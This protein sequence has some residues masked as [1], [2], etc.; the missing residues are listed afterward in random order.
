MTEKRNS[1][2]LCLA[3]KRRNENLRRRIKT[4]F[5]RSHELGKANGVDVA[6]V[7]R[8]NNQYYTFRS[9]DQPAWPLTMTDIVSGT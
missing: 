3:V 7:L 4:L 1:Q 2:V 8:K 9:I 5:I 6:V